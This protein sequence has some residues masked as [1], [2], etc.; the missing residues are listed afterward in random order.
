MMYDEAVAAARAEALK[1][2]DAHRHGTVGTS[3]DTAEAMEPVLGALK[4]VMAVAHMMVGTQGRAEPIALEIYKA[5]REAGPICQVARVAIHQS[6]K[7]LKEDIVCCCPEM[8]NVYAKQEYAVTLE[9][10]F[11]AGISAQ[12]LLKNINH[13]LSEPN[14]AFTGIMGSM[15]N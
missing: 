9:E 5:H 14:Q 12:M 11:K 2:E 8:H 3:K 1:F 4:R 7:L 13:F 15:K 6:G 10:L